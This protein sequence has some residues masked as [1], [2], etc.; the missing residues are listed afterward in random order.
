M[1]R[2]S[3]LLALTLPAGSLT[4]CSGALDQAHSVQT[5]LNRI[6]EVTDAQVSTPSA[7]TGAAIEVTYDDVASARTLTRLV[8]DIDDVAD[9]EDYPSYR[10][11]LVPADNDRDRLTVDDAF[12]GSD[13]EPT[14]LANWFATTSALLGDV[15]YRFEPGAESIDV[16]S[17]AGI[18]HDVGE[19]SRIRYGFPG[20]VWTFRDEDSAF[21]ASGRVSPTDVLLFEGAER[22]VTSEV[23][24]APATVWHLERRDGHVL[25]D[26]DVGFP[27]GSVPPERLTT[28]R[29]G[30]DVERLAGAAMAAA[31]VASLPVALRL[32]NVTPD[33]DDVFG[34]WASDQ[35]P[36]RGRDALVRGWDRWL[37]HL[38]DHPAGSAT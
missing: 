32:V 31:E 15:R 2:A 12:A 37:S 9:G 36:V 35:R 14:V 10:L 38:A 26:L 5:R 23:L 34:Y 20:T 29:Y 22:T 18:A 6:E 30:G 21:V 13:A 28:Q 17:G 16:D 4:A 19:A 27:G 25:M 3:A 11:D 7:D 1:A 8:K 33:G 24:P